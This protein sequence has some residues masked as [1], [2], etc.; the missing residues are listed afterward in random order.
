VIE[1]QVPIDGAQCVKCKGKLE[2]I[3]INGVLLAYYCSN[4]FCEI[5]GLLTRAIVRTEAVEALAAKGA[6]KG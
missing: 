2:H 3:A 6:P 4:D 1:V 5:A